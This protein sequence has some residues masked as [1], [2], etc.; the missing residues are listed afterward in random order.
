MNSYFTSSFTSP[1]GS[2]AQVHLLLHHSSSGTDRK[3]RLFISFAVRKYIFSKALCLL[4]PGISAGFVSPRSLQSLWSFFHQVAWPRCFNCVGY[5]R[6][7]QWDDA[8]CKW[9]QSFDSVGVTLHNDADQLWSVCVS[10][11]H[12]EIP[13]CRC[14]TRLSLSIIC[15]L[16]FSRRTRERSLT[17]RFSGTR[18][19]ASV[20]NPSYR[21]SVD[22]NR[23]SECVAC[24][25]KWC[26]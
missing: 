3:G 12:G 25:V 26:D 23:R 11:S 15:A 1:A 8:K 20:L 6:F 5:C 9:G 22:P 4:L 24:C 21:S 7:T 2:T 14:D 13:W 19:C 17:Q 10:L 18:S 16:I